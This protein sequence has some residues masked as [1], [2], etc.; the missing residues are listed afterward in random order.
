MHGGPK[1]I[2]SSSFISNWQF[3]PC[4][5]HMAVFLNLIADGFS[6][7]FFGNLWLVRSNTSENRQVFG[8]AARRYSWQL[9]SFCTS[10]LQRMIFFRTWEQN[11]PKQIPESTPKITILLWCQ[12]GCC[13]FEMEPG[14]QPPKII[15][16]FLNVRPC[17]ST[18]FYPWK[19]GEAWLLPGQSLFHILFTKQH[20]RTQE[21]IVCPFPEI[22]CQRQAVC[23]S[24][25]YLGLV[26]SDLFDLVIRCS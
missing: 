20:R 3:C 22:L 13:K 9:R 12:S 18:A 21:Q 19:H 2:I 15:G 26:F 8:N 10:G 16:C 25:V 11:H 23:Y 7:R 1:T 4:V 17:S 6:I 24:H 14:F 5:T